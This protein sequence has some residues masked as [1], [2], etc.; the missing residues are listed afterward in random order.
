MD[1]A[2][3]NK[4]FDSFICHVQD[5]T[6][7]I[8]NNSTILSCFH[9]I[10]SAHIQAGNVGNCTEELCY[11]YSQNN[12]NYVSLPAQQ[13]R[14][15]NVVNTQLANQLLCLYNTRLRG[16]KCGSCG[17]HEDGLELCTD[18]PSVLCDAHKKG[19]AHK[20]FGANHHFESLQDSNEKIL[21]SALK[22][23]AFRK[24]DNDALETRISTVLMY[25]ESNEKRLADIQ[26]FMDKIHN[27]TRDVIEEA[28][29][30][31]EKIVRHV[32][33][34]KNELFE[35]LNSKSDELLRDQ[36]EFCRNLEFKSS[37]AERAL[38]LYR[39]VKQSRMRVTNKFVRMFSSESL[40]FT[41][42][43]FPIA[44]PP[45]ELKNIPT[46][47]HRIQENLEFLHPIQQQQQPPTHCKGK[48]YFK[49][50]KD[51]SVPAC[52][53]L[54]SCEL[55]DRK[56]I[57]VV[58]DDFPKFNIKTRS[59]TIYHD[60]H[61]LKQMDN[62]IQI[63][64]HSDETIPVTFEELMNKTKITKIVCTWIASNQEK[65]K[66]TICVVPHKVS[67]FSLTPGKLSSVARSGDKLFGI[68]QNGKE[69]IRLNCPSA[70]ICNQMDEQVPSNLTVEKSFGLNHLTAPK[71]ICVLGE[72][73]FVSDESHHAVFCFSDDG[74]FLDKF[75]RIGSHAGQFNRPMGLAG[76]QE[77][78]RLIVADSGNRR[79]QILRLNQEWEYFELRGDIEEDDFPIDVRLDTLG[80]FYILTN[81]RA[82][83]HYD[84]KFTFRTFVLH[85][86]TIDIKPFF[87]MDGN[88]VIY[89]WSEVDGVCTIRYIHN[90]VCNF[91]TVR[92]IPKSLRPVGMTV[93][94]EGRLYLTHHKTDDPGLPSTL[95]YIVTQLAFKDT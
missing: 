55:T 32:E 64:G 37:A 15:V 39:F 87:A 7:Q 5:C 61:V 8:S 86:S 75:G 45:I 30:N 13:H 65:K 66:V 34:M 94:D 17:V 6:N 53:G 16:A 47:L 51:N 38:V 44:Q 33:K 31:F 50:E 3:E 9:S 60:D 12:P 24:A 80:S 58:I 77:H 52:H 69:I 91:N 49:G 93:D 79:V 41:E 18:C 92:G 72:Q 29:A 59:Y 89:L 22:R 21:D 26:T 36:Q 48:Y 46:I 54:K 25:K 56:V 42:Q 10:C 63:A 2:N 1:F 67:V 35:K 27:N 95:V 70:L 84:H 40:S 90:E 20:R 76:D 88:D 74:T 85:P 23:K 11:S 83:L 82:I 57:F 19:E 14:C 78:D 73:V 81:S 28:N 71:G 43:L 62:V 68:S 4:I